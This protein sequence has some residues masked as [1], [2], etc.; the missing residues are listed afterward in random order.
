MAE[1][2]VY[3]NLVTVRDST[4][5][6]QRAHGRRNKGSDARGFLYPVA[7]SHFIFLKMIN[8]ITAM[9]AMTAISPI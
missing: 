4:S 2:P 9:A 1:W 3:A 7:H 6:P 5:A 8:W